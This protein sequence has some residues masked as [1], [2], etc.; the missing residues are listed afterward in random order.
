MVNTDKLVVST[1]AE[2]LQWITLLGKCSDFHYDMSGQFN[3]E[4][5]VADIHRAWA[6]A[7]RDAVLLI[8]M[9]AVEEAEV[10][11]DPRPPSER[12][13]KVNEDKDAE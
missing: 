8:E 9:W 12:A 5:D 4:K 3:E 1:D 13:T 7:I 10:K 11:V 6:A 2:R